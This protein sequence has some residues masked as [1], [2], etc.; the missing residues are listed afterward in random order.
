MINIEKYK[1]KA[2]P[3]DVEQDIAWALG[4]DPSHVQHDLA[5]RLERLGYNALV[6]VYARQGR[7]PQY[8]VIIRDVDSGDETTAIYA[9]NGDVL[10]CSCSKLYGG[11]FKGI[12]IDYQDS[13]IV[14]YNGTSCQ[15]INRLD[16]CLV[17]GI[18]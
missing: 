9:G 1:Y 17:S 5:E 15:E 3:C 16:T 8:D 11:P 10:A 2:W 4:F 6:R 14:L 12:T 13:K 18:R 7:H